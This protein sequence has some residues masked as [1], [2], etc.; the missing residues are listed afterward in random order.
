MKL[1]YIYSYHKIIQNLKDVILRLSSFK[2]L[3]ECTDLFKI[4]N[5]KLSPIFLKLK[6]NL[7]LKSQ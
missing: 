7:L 5:K 4:S 2:S 3:K 6:T 1:V